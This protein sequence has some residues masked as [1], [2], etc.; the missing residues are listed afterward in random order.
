MRI[1]EGPKGDREGAEPVG[2]RLALQWHRDPEFR[3]SSLG[4]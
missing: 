3:L 4:R 1:V 2:T